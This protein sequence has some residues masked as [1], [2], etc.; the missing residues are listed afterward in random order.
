MTEVWRIFYRTQSEFLP[1]SL[2]WGWWCFWRFVVHYHAW[3]SRSSLFCLLSVDCD[4][5]NLFGS[6]FQT[7][8]MSLISHR[9]WVLSLGGIWA[10]LSNCLSCC[11][12]CLN[13]CLS[14]IVEGPTKSGLLQLSQGCSHC[15]IV[16]DLWS[17]LSFVFLKKSQGSSRE[18]LLELLSTCEGTLPVLSH[19]GYHSDEKR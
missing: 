10:T 6:E 5:S 16:A 2:C 18:S 12:N 11:W 17:A 7:N 8:R 15:E 9:M 14:P 4:F 1:N 19:L 3:V 13:Y